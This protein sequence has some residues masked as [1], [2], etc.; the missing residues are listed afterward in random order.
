MS[1]ECQKLREEN[2]VLHQ[3]TRMS[4]NLKEHEDQVKH[5]VTNNKQLSEK[6]DVESYECKKHLRHMEDELDE[7]KL[8]V[9]KRDLHISQI[10]CENKVL[11]KMICK[12][13]ELVHSL[14]ITVRYK[15]I[16]LYQLY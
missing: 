4:I 5:L 11:K 9:G 15:F 16:F 10:E 12:Y 7:F 1:D 13:E 6:L 14:R 3:K 2:K 8:K